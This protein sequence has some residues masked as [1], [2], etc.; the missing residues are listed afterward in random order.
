MGHVLFVAL[1]FPV[2]L[3]LLAPASLMLGLTGS[4]SCVMQSSLYQCLL[5]LRCASTLWCHKGPLSLGCYV[6][7]PFNTRGGQNKASFFLFFSRKLKLIFFAEGQLQ[8]VINFKRMRFCCFFS[9]MFFSP[10]GA[11]AKYK[12]PCAGHGA[13]F[14]NRSRRCFW[15]RQ[16]AAFLSAG[17]KGHRGGEQGEADRW[18]VQ[19]GG[20]L[21][22]FY[23]LSAMSCRLARAA[24][25][26]AFS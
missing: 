12:H 6:L 25:R 4:R 24:A 11:A 15:T 7:E 18:R 20:R 3:L 17:G 9:L 10:P 26:S 13:L 1:L 5:M 19:G 14:W 22:S 21:Q 2:F 8:S 16:L 23:A